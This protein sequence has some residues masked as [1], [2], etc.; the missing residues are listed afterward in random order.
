[1]NVLSK[2]KKYTTQFLASKY[3]QGF[4]NWIIRACSLALSAG[5]IHQYIRHSIQAQD[6]RRGYFATAS[7]VV[8]AFVCNFGLWVITTPKA[9]TNRIF[10][11]FA[12]LPTFLI[13]PMIAD[14]YIGDCAYFIYGLG[15]VAV[16]R[17]FIKV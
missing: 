3:I 4:V 8:V 16:A 7:A 12:L 10:S 13:S 9:N 5:Y 11:F 17:I 15:V 2:S 6:F 1:M 14:F